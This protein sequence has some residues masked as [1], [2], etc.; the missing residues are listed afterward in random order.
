MSLFPHTCFYTCFFLSREI[1]QTWS[2][3]R[4]PNISELQLPEFLVIIKLD[5]AMLGYECALYEQKNSMGVFSPL[6]SI[7]FYSCANLFRFN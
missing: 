7:L 2:C 6:S 1:K 5:K 3:G 4:I